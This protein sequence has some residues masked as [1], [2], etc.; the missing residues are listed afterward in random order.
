MRSQLAL[1]TS[2]RLRTKWCRFTSRT[3][4][5]CVWLSRSWRLDSLSWHFLKR[6]LSSRITTRIF[7]PVKAIKMKRWGSK[8]RRFGR[9]CWRSMFRF[10]DNFIRETCGAVSAHPTTGLHRHSSFHSVGRKILTFL[11][12]AGL[13][14]SSRFETSPGKI[15]TRVHRSAPS[16]FAPSQSSKRFHSSFPSTSAS[17]CF[18]VCLQLRS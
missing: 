15:W 8:R 17:K 4:C 1:L 7:S 6:E 2:N 12:D 16:R 18:K 3:L 5:T 14:R 11:L 9:N 10:C 13:D